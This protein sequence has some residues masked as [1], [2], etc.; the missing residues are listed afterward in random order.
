ME[1]FIILFTV[2]YWVTSEKLLG[3]FRET[4]LTKWKKI[5]ETYSEWESIHERSSSYLKYFEINYQR[6]SEKENFL[7]KKV[8]NLIAPKLVYLGV[9]LE[10]FRIYQNAFSEKYKVVEE[11]YLTG[12]IIKIIK[13]SNLI[14]RPIQLEHLEISNGELIEKLQEYSDRIEDIVNEL[15]SMENGIKNF[16][17]QLWRFQEIEQEIVDVENYFVRDK[18]LID[19]YGEIYFRAI[20]RQKKRFSWEKPLVMSSINCSLASGKFH[21]AANNLFDFVERLSLGNFLLEHLPG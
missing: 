21:D 1:I 8:G 14:E 5:I 4:Y 2:F 6:Y 19:E 10:Q 9:Y 12:D 17:H 15:Q 3:L 18:K 7:Q 13:V 16:Y 11:A 20:D